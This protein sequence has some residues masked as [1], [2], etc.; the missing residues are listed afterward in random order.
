MMAI[1]VT[2]QPIT[3]ADLQRVDGLDEYKGMEIVDGVWTPKHEGEGMS[4]GHGAFGVNLIIHLGSYIKQHHLGELYMSDTIFVL[5]V[6]NNKVR[7]VRKP[8]I[9]FVSTPKVIPNPGDYYFEAPDIAVEIISPSDRRPGVLHGK[10]TDYFT[11]GT[12]QVWL[13]YHEE[14]QIVIQNV[15]GTGQVYRLGDTISDI[16]L[17]PG[18]TLAVADVFQR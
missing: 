10:L 7:T 3:L 5:H 9:A 15:D 16:E 4:A 2:T 18:F 1:P 8:D 6:H 13:V 11:Y 12:Q 14:K 17:L